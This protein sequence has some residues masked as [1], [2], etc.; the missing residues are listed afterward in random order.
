MALITTPQVNSVFSTGNSKLSGAV[1]V[2]GGT[3]CSISGIGS[4]F[5]T[6]FTGSVGS[7]LRNFSNNTTFS[8][9]NSTSLNTTLFTIPITNGKSYAFKSFLSVYSASATPDFQM[10]FKT[11]STASLSGLLRNWFHI[12]GSISDHELRNTTMAVSSTDYT[13][14]IALTANNRFFV[15]GQGHMTCTG[16]GNLSLVFSQNTLDSVNATNIDRYSW[17]QI[18]EV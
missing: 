2:T 6:A 7:N 13:Y 14:V 18:W 1:T 16:T 17:F 12:Q 4:V 15:M 9:L 5:T 3:N 11:D 10:A 8:S